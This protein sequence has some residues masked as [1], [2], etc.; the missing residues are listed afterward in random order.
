MIDDD[1][2]VKAVVVDNRHV[3]PGE[4][5]FIVAEIGTSHRGDLDR[6]RELVDR[7]AEA[8]ADCAKFQIVIADEIVHP[9]TGLVSLPGGETPLFE[10][11]RAMERPPA[12][13]RSLK[14]ITEERGLVF[15]CSPFGERSARVLFDLGCGVVKIASPEVNHFPLLDVVGQNGATAVVSTGVS[16][17]ADTEAALGRLRR[18]GCRGRIVLHCVT[19]YPAPEAEYNVRVIRNLSRILGVPVGLSDHSLDPVLVPVLSTACG[20]AVIEK[21][22]TLSRDDGGLDDLVA[23][24]PAGFAEMVA[25]VRAAE[26]D[27]PEAV[28]RRMF[29]V[30]GE[31][32]VRSVLGDGVKRMA[33]SEQANYETTNR[34]I[35]AVSDIAAGEI[36]NVSNIALL[37]S[38]KNLRPGVPGRYWDLILGS[39]AVRH[40]PNGRGVQWADVIVREGD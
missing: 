33:D 15:L 11:F 8:G 36:L 20:A 17:L 9:S 35:I 30:Y 18:S 38:E 22:L 10:V 1:R 23:L 5:V 27:E 7:A 24:T 28:V 14:Q 37:R 16:T 32:T 31:S 13:Y 21:H 4:P 26:S 2:L 12:F 39:T 40:V 34:S 6:A 29:R 25:G 19:S 3:G